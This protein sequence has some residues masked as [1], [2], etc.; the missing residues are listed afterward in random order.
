MPAAASGQKSAA[1]NAPEA[2]GTTVVMA[3]GIDDASN[4]LIV[5]MVSLVNQWQDA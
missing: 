1:C 3:I 2:I 5:G 4:G